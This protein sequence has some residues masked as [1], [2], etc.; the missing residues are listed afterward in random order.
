MLILTSVRRTAPIAAT[1]TVTAGLLLAACGSSAPP[2]NLISVSNGGCG[3]DWHVA[4]PGPYTFQIYNAAAEEGDV[5]LI[6][7]ASGAIYAEVEMLGPTTTSSMQLD[8]GSGQY[9][10]R[11]SFEDF[12]PFNGPTETVSGDVTGT[13]GIL[14]VTQDDLLLPAKQYT[15]YVTKGL[16]TL[17][18][19]TA[20]LLGDVRAGN[21]TQAKADWL[22]AHLE[23][24]RLGAAYDA[25][26]NFD[27]EIDGRPDG[28]V[29]GVNSPQWTGFYR[30]EYGLWHGQSQHTLASVATTLDN[31]V[32]G[33]KA[34][35]PN[36][37]GMQI[38]LLLLGLRTHEIMENALEFQLSGHDDFGSGTTLATTVANI[39]GDEELLTLLHPLLVP[40]YAQLPAVY[41]WL[42]RLQSLLYQYGYQN[43]RWI[44]VASLSAA[45]R[46][47]IDSA[48]DQAV[49]EL[50]P[51]ATITE[52]R[53]V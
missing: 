38:Q 1:I 31:D 10:F 39:A 23:Y 12:D 18:G 9:A 24:Q 29:G 42:D 43:G 4:K 16:A 21:L 51:I 40:R 35:W 52:P 37:S 13:P 7:P 27:D 20:T 46:E 50:A 2:A 14:P 36:G 47:Q 49:E 33:L 26:G 17:A 15:S 44:S 8:L 19:E 32:L 30:L 28:L 11:C 25:F 48:C 45:D 53:G 5:D 3:G 34:A 22:T 6:N 41:T